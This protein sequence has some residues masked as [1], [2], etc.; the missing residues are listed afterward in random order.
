[1]RVLDLFCCEGGASTGLKRAWPDAE[2]VG[3]DIKPQPRYPFAFVQAD[4]L[5][6]P[7]GGFDFIWA[8]PPCQAFSALNNRFSLDPS[9]HPDLI[10]PIR[11]RLW[12]TEVPF[13]IENVPG[14]PLERPVMLCGSMFGLRLNGRGYLRRHRLF[15]SSAPIMVPQCQHDGRAL[16]VYGH[17][18]SDGKTGGLKLG[19]DDAREIME[20]PWASRDGVAQ[21]IP[22]AYSEFIAKQVFRWT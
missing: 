10:A 19:A 9:R 5:E 11:K 21:A 12:A 1:V 22:P 2:I 20:M 15:E 16:G 17:G 14:A 18:A 8:S 4:A 13:V 7:L 3:V 6:Y